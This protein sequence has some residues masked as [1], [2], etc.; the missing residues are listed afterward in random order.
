MSLSLSARQRQ[1]APIVIGL[2][3]FMAALAVLRIELRA[4]SWHTLVDAAL[5]V[6]RGRLAAAAALTVLNYLALTGY[7][8]MAF[9]YAG[10]RLPRSQIVAASLFAYA[11][12]NA[13]GFAML[14]G[15]SVRYRFYSRWGVTAEELSRVVLAYSITFWLGLFALGGASLLASG[16]AIATRFG[17]AA[18]VARAGW[19]LLLVPVMYVAASALRRQPIRLLRFQLGLP[20]ARLAAGQLVLSSIDWALAGAVLFVL[21]PAGALPFITFLGLFLIAILIGMISHVPGGIGVFEGVMVLL[22]A[23]YLPS[24]AVIPALVVFR[25]IYYLAPLCLA[26]AGLIVDEAWQRR[27]H[28]ARVANGAGRLTAQLTPPAMAALTF[29]AGVVLLV[30]GA[31]PAAPGR[32][33][34]LHGLLPLGVIEI[35]HF[36]GSVAG[37]ALLVVSQGLARRLDAA[38]YLTAGAIVAGMAASL[39]KGFD[40]EE[41]TLLLVMLAILWGARPAFDRKAAFLETRF[42]ASW[43][44]ALIAAVSASVWL[45]FFAFQHVAYSNELWWQFELHGEASRFLR[46]SVGASM[47]LM[48][49]GLA[50]LVRQRPPDAPVPTSTDLDDAARIIAAQGATSPMLV[51]LRDKSLLFNAS[52]TGFVMYAVQGRS[53]VALGDP[54]GPPDQR[55]DLVRLFLE[56][57]NDFG[58]V[59]VF[60]EIGASHLHAYADFGLRFV[61]IGEEARVDLSRFSLEGGAAARYRQAIRRVEKAGATFRVL[62]AADVAPRLPEL[63]EVSDQ[64]LA[65]KSSAEK[66]FS[67]GFFNEAYVARFPVAVIECG[68]RIVAFANI[69]TAADGGEVSIDL[70]RYGRDAPPGIMESLIVHIMRWGHQHGYRQF[71]LG[72]APL[73]GFES[74]PMASLWN[75]LGA[76]IYEHGDALYHFQGLRAFKEK[77]ASAWEPHYLAYPGGLRLPRVLADVSALVAGGYRQIFRK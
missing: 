28:V 1:A 71:V 64:W 26:L 14:T 77:F 39:L 75:R 74:S 67:L 38:Y 56:R 33:A 23:P 46:A 30:S 45:G 63:R 32:L 8:L 57:C 60:Y 4:L 35:S 3:V 54:V 73:S 7:D 58:G 36:A 68:G 70:M 76:F 17:A 15:A 10:R 65:L 49:L 34:L 16:E 48:L 43:L 18:V 72:M 20:S 42:S 11:V 55:A 12:S 9:A 44:A 27:V 24:T 52:R 31:T 50:R 25:V 2:V 5:R 66:G 41:A 61:K 19:I 13:I 37:A 53:W 22:L 29:L 69:W 6:P 21:L 47:V 59:P 40:Y 62:A 51:F